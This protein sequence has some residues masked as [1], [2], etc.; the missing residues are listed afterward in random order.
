MPE[1]NIV[2]LTCNISG[3]LH[4]AAHWI[5]SRPPLADY[6]LQLQP[7]GCGMTIGVFKVPVE[8]EAEVSTLL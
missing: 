2:I 5:N 6:L 7:A 3:N 1:Q 8:D 4:T